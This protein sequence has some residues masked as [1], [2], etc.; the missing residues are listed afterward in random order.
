MRLHRLVPKIASRP[1]NVEMTGIHDQRATN[2]GAIEAMI[3]GEF[4][5]VT[6]AAR[7]LDEVLVEPA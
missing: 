3:A 7:Q 6:G 2:W 1:C 4:G 5:L